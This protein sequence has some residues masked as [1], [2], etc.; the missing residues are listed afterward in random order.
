LWVY[1]LGGI[2]LTSLVAGIYLLSVDSSLTCD[3]G[4]NEQCREQYATASAGYAFTL[5]GLAVGGLAGYLFYTVY[6]NDGEPKVAVTPTVSGNA[7]GLMLSIR[8]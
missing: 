2:A 3:S 4:Y 7:K 8:F 1:A 5:T 6:M